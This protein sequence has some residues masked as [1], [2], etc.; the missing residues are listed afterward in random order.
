MLISNDILGGRL[1]GLRTN[2]GGGGGGGVTMHK[3]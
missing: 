3:K 1:K 2:D